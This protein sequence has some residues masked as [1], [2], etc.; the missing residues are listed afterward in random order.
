MVVDDL[1]NFQIDRVIILSVIARQTH[2]HTD[3]HIRISVIGIDNTIQE[4][5]STDLY[6]TNYNLCLLDIVGEN[7]HPGKLFLLIFTKGIPVV[8]TITSFRKVL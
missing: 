1:T 2:R 5:S 8:L 4:I 3:R 7:L 6:Y